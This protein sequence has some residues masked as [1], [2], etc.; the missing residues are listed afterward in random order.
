MTGAGK[1][2]RFKPALPISRREQR[3]IDTFSN[4]IRT[5]V[6]VFDNNNLKNTVADVVKKIDRS[7]RYVWGAIKPGRHAI[8]AISR[9]AK[10]NKI[11]RACL[12]L[13]FTLRSGPKPVKD[14]EALAREIGV[15]L[16][17][18]RRAS[19]DLVT[20]TREGGRYGRYVWELSARTKKFFEIEG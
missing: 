16:R 4:R 9:L 7:E 5:G 10:A 15:G 18:L 3:E 14:I 17:T 12:M 13:L 1:K 19:E 8:E 11:H 20:I 2:T 6:L